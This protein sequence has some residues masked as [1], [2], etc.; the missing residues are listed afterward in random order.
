[1]LG[2]SAEILGNAVAP[3]FPGADAVL[4]TAV[5]ASLAALAS[6]GLSVED[7]AA[8]GVGVP[9]RVDP[10][11]GMVRDA[12][13]LGIDSFDLRA[14]LQARLGLPVR[15]DND[16]NTAAVAAYDAYGDGLRAVAYLNLG[17]GLA[18]GLVVDGRLWRGA[19][20]VAGEVGHVVAD[21][22]GE[23][24]TCGQ[25]GCLETIASGRA[26]ARDWPVTDGHPALALFAAAVGLD[27]RALHLAGTF[28]RG[29]LL[30]A[31]TL[32]LTLDVDRIL[33]GGGLAGLGAPLLELVRRVEQED[34]ASSPF[35]ASLHVAERMRLLPP[36]YP[37]GAVGAA[38]LSPAFARTDAREGEGSRG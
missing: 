22:G 27:P 34:C 15:V 19:T 32:V 33:V 24:C 3:T 21:L 13:N 14:A 9:G 6:G 25:R 17:T 2:P 11:S 1:V 10:D 8:V 38:L 35:L 7:V 12:V 28:A 29:V 37:V 16:V 36:E 31:R 20:G 18:A 26:L 23:L 5:A 30:A 4:E